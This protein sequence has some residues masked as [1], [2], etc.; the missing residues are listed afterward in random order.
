MG[1]ADD[2]SDEC[3]EG[4]V[5]NDFDAVVNSALVTFYGIRS[6]LISES[7]RALSAGSRRSEWA[8]GGCGGGRAQCGRWRA[9][10]ISALC[11]PAEL[12]GVKFC[13]RNMWI[14]DGTLC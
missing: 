12:R 9:I 4:F 8:S 3:S 14:V 7:G 1:F 2:V 5:R 10:T 6:F 11:I 13:P